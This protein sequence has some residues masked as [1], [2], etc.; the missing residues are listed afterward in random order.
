MTNNLPVNAGRLF[1]YAN[2]LQDEIHRCILVDV[3]IID[4]S[5]NSFDKKEGMGFGVIL[6]RGSRDFISAARREQGDWHEV[7]GMHGHQ[8]ISFGIADIALSCR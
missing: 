3:S 6:F 5:I 8:P 4:I 7:R 2:G 1:E